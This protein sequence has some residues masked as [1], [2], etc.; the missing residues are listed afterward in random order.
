MYLHTLRSLNK[1]L[2]SR[3]TIWL[4]AAID[5]FWEKSEFVLKAGLLCVR[6]WCIV[7]IH[8]VSTKL[9]QM[10]ML[11]LAIIEIAQL[12]TYIQLV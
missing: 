8:K 2:D 3:G 4:G 7:L 1:Y 10:C 12:R 5:A 11:G 9:V 6:I